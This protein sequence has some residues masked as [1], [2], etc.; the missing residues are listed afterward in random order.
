MYSLFSKF[1]QTA[2][3]HFLRFSSVATNSSSSLTHR[4]SSPSL[5]ITSVQLKEK[6]LS[7][8]W[9]NS[10]TVDLPYVFLRDN[11]QEPESFDQVARQRLFNP[12]FTVDL[13][14]RATDAQVNEDGKQLTITW[15]DG[16]HSRYKSTWLGRHCIG[17]TTM[18]GR[19][20]VETVHWEGDY[21][22]KMPR[23]DFEML[24][25]DDRCLLECLLKVESHGLVLLENVGTQLNQVKRLCDHIY[26]PKPSIYG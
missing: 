5:R 26:Y 3:L 6:Q 4:F 8:Q 14:I 25:E 24:L 2:R 15:P 16:H 1:R 17:N 21:Y 20:P 11:C 10:N 23:F 19:L 7:I 22:D 18:S 9:N 13:N 12:A